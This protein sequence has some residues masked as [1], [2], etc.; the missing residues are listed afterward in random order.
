MIL[1]LFFY[2]T[3]GLLFVGCDYFEDVKIVPSGKV[4]KVGVLAPLSGQHKRYGTQSLL[5]LKSAHKMH[6]YLT[7][8]DKIIF[9]IVDAKSDN[10]SSLEALCKLKDKNV[11]SIISFLGSNHMLALSP[12]FDMKKIPVIAT[13]ATHS[14][15]SKDTQYVSQVCMSNHMQTLVASH[16]LRD[17]KLIEN[18][19]IVYNKQSTYSQALADEFQIYFKDI[20]GQ[21][22]FYIDVSSE[23]G[24]EK[25]HSQKNETTQMLFNVT[26]AEQS[27]TLINALH[28]LHWEIEILGTDGL[29]SDALEHS[30]ED[31]ELFD[32]LY[33]VEHY[34]HNK[35]VTKKQKQFK[36]YL[37]NKNLQE[38]SYAYLAYDGYQLLMN[39]LENCQN[40]ERQCINAMLHDSGIIEGISGNFSM[41]NAKANRAIYID[42]IKNAKLI[43]EVIIY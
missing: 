37:N 18:I 7:N 9:E 3:V 11:S 34:A 40:Y 38:S 32:D 30:S 36:N 23:E 19:G 10:N 43:K 39:A 17:E 28:A 27:V 2:I 21:I 41:K 24:I 33:V 4:V 6:Q 42:R 29:L 31:V 15:I 16:Y 13:I 26:D 22:D 8:G 20:G 12:Y 5:G 25:F 1:R 14:D 35:T